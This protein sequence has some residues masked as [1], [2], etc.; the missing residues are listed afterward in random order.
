MVTRSTSLL[1]LLAVL[2]LVAC[3][4]GQGGAPSQSEST[5]PDGSE[6]LF[7]PNHVIDVHVELAPG[8]WD[9]LRDEGRSF[10]DVFSGCTEGFEYTYFSATVTV[11]GEVYEEVAVRKKGFL[12][13]LS[14][15]RPSL[16]LNFGKFVPDRIF[17][18]KKRLTLN[19]NLQDPGNTHQCMAYALFA[20]AGAI[21]PR[22]NFARVWV[23]G[24]DLGIYSNIEP[25]K[26]RMLRRHFADDE[27]NL[28]EGQGADF[29]DTR[30][31]RMELKTNEAENDRRDLDAVTA[32]LKTDD[33]QLFDALGRV[34]DIDSFLTFWAMEVITGHWDSYSG[35]RNN[36]LTY[37]DPTTDK[38]FFI[39]WGTDGA[40]SQ[41]RIFS[42]DNRDPAVLAEGAIANRIYEHPQGRAM[43]FERLGELFDLVWHEDD[44]LAEVDRI[45]A[46]TSAPERALDVQRAFILQQGTDLRAA[47]GRD[48]RDAPDWIDGPL[49]D[50]TPICSEGRTTRVS[51]SFSTTWG[52]QPSPG[53][54]LSLDIVVNG[55][56][57]EPAQ[58]LGAAGFDTVSD[59]GTNILLLS[60]QPGGEILVVVL[61]I[62]SVLFTEGRHKMHGIET[63]VLLVKI[64]PARPQSPDIVGFGGGD[65][66]ITLDAASMTLGGAVEGTFEADFLQIRPF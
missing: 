12:G 11:D 54:G 45:G 6:A 1:S 64:D 24:E 51:G 63:S 37:H 25:V 49:G 14:A 4:P 48:V 58:L 18:G 59:A 42:G 28:Y 8:D 9:A 35:G 33:D 16:K 41:T 34:V 31:D 29:I 23:N 2:F 36:Y 10:T 53:P 21:A 5:G 13:S 44:L 30:V 65:G 56:R 57:L 39:P 61:R 15:L 20:Q 47:L 26:K 38:F 40:F 50:A 52:G 17:Q 27:G 43:Y 55:E 7:E 62:P 46:L 3:G 19:N 22:C 60:P 32:A 66:H